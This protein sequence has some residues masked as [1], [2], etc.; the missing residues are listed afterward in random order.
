[1][2]DFTSDLT[3]FVTFIKILVLTFRSVDRFISIRCFFSQPW[4]TVT[5]FFSAFLLAAVVFTGSLFLLYHIAFF[6]FVVR[7]ISQTFFDIFI[8]LAKF[9]LGFIHCLVYEITFRK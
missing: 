1:M 4:L 7:R 5:F 8:G 9:I 6:S 2:G 3:S